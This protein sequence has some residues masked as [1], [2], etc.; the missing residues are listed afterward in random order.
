[1]MGTGSSS[2]A[3][4]DRVAARLR[5]SVIILSFI[6]SASSRSIQNIFLRIK[7]TVDVPRGSSSAISSTDKASSLSCSPDDF[8]ERGII[9]SSVKTGVEADDL[10]AVAVS[11][12]SS[13]SIGISSEA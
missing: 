10:R 3:V 11:A 5:A 2:A 13:D 7:S 8:R 6:C 4:L 12:A 9:C 1:M